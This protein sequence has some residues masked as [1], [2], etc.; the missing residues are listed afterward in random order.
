MI[1]NIMVL[2]FTN[3]IFES[4]WNNKYIDNI[5]ISLT[6]K[7]GVGTRGGYYEHSGAMRYDSKS[8]NADSILGSYGASGKLKD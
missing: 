8:Y 2:R 1:Q 6:E 3:S 7:L 5:Q 4:I